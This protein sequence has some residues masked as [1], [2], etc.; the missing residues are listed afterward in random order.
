MAEP[1]S[2]AASRDEQKEREKQQIENEK[3]EKRLEK[4][5]E[6]QQRENEK[7]E[8][9]LERE[10][11]KQEERERK[12]KEKEAKAQQKQQA[13]SSVERS[14]PPT[15]GENS[16]Q[17]G[18]ILVA[19]GSPE[20]VDE[21]KIQRPAENGLSPNGHTT[22]PLSPNEAEIAD[23]AQ[24]Q[25]A[26]SAAES[27]GVTVVKPPGQIT[28]Y[29]QPIGIVFDATRAGTGTLTASCL[30]AKVGDVPTTV[31]K[32]RE[33]VLNVAFTPNVADM[34]TLRV[35]WGGKEVTGSPFNI[36][37]SHIPPAPQEQNARVPPAPQ[38]QNARVPPAPQ[39]QKARVL[40]A[41][42]EQKSTQQTEKEEEEELSDDPF[43]MALQARRVL[44]EQQRQAEFR[45]PRQPPNSTDTSHSPSPQPKSTPVRANHLEHTPPRH[46]PVNQPMAQNGLHL[47]HPMSAAQ[48]PMPHPVMSPAREEDVRHLHEVNET[49]Q[50]SSQGLEVEVADLKKKM[51]EF[52]AK[53]ST[54]EQ[55]SQA[56]AEEKKELMAHIN[57]RGWLHKRGI[58]GPTANVWRQRYFR[59]DQGS[60]IYYYKA[61]DEA[62]PRGYI[63]LEKV[64][65]V[66]EVSL[67]DPQPEPGSGAAD[68]NIVC[69][70]RTFQLRADN[71][72]TRKKWISAVEYLK[73][74]HQKNE[75][76]LSMPTLS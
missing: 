17:N 30:G 49:V 72:E 36:N 8:K 26:R 56:A 19:D 2:S 74:W 43:D 52:E 51:G 4:E 29:G 16:Q 39:E 47:P 18:G 22:Y 63:D 68:F 3:R 32:M 66:E 62:T 64:E 65:N 57:I 55:T 44:E 61:A 6:K 1:D 14:P 76:A 75:S 11:K 31:T 70:E 7:R 21:L 50:Q 33:G 9:K 67:S 28:G 35:R 23:A 54:I 37:L 73:D 53:L 24:Q 41:P 40:P 45:S 71:D 46:S 42:Q 5:R 15:E 60:K 20:H 69:G 27:G 58:K 12:K 25:T 38:E 34:Y 59:C 10:R 48:S 13:R